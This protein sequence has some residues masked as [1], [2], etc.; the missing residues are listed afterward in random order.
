MEQWSS[1]DKGQI[2]KAVEDSALILKSMA[3][4]L[5]SSKASE[6]D[7]VIVNRHERE[8][9]LAKKEACYWEKLEKASKSKRQ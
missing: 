9:A 5:R 1:L 3:A 6:S 4:E 7:P 2:E 8:L